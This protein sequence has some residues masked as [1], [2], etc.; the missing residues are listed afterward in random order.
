MRWGACAD[1]EVLSEWP[2]Q[3]SNFDVFFF[4]FFLVEEQK[5]GHRDQ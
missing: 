3:L 1:P 5:R 4:F 2:V